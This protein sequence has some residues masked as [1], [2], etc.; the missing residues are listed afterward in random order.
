[1]ILCVVS[2]YYSR[3]FKSVTKLLTWDNKFSRNRAMSE[4]LRG[5]GDI[6][7]RTFNNSEIRA[8]EK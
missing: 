8:E 4:M 1:M 6:T 3:S 7:S 2:L 5:T